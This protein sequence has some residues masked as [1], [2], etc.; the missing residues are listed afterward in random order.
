MRSVFIHL[1]TTTE[2]EV[3]AFLDSAFTQQA[4]RQWIS[5][6]DGDAC[7]YID[8]YR[9]HAAESE[10]DDHAALLRVFGGR[11]PVSVIADVSGR[12]PGDD[13]VRE[14]VRRLLERFAGFAQDD[15][16]AR[17]WSLEEVL[18]HADV[19]GHPFFD[20]RAQRP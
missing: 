16:S 4:G 10:P 8:F 18:S 11:A 2:T 7:L 20:Y 15:Y 1:A 6:I 3:A 14:L 13:Q 9:D 5:A 12:W 19:D 17:L